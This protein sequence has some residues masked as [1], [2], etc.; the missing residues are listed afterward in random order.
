MTSASQKPQSV[1]STRNLLT[2]QEKK[3]I[4]RRNYYL[5][6]KE[7]VKEK[8]KKWRLANRERKKETMRLWHATHLKRKTEIEKKYLNTP[9]GKETQRK[10]LARRQQLGF[11]P[12]NKP[13]PGAHK[14]HIDIARV[15]YIPR[16]LH[17]SIKHSVFTNLNMEVI[18]QTAFEFLH[19]QGRP[20]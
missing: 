4:A 2:P 11:I 16:K 19:S 8:D 1:V 9:K 20:L 17:R 7:Q 15:I 3:R 12:L 5:S 18:N 14:H 10:R 13:F 6:H